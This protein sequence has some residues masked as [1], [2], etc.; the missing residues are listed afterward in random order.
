MLQGWVHR[1]CHKSVRLLDSV[2]LLHRAEI[3]PASTYT[4]NTALAFAP[5]VS[6]CLLPSWTIPYIHQFPPICLVRKVHLVS[7][8]SGRPMQRRP[9]AALRLKVGTTT[10]EQLQR[11]Q[12]PVPG[13]AV[14][15]GDPLSICRAHVGPQGRQPRRGLMA[16]GDESQGKWRQAMVVLVNR[17]I[18][19]CNHA[20]ADRFAK[21][22]WLQ[23]LTH[24]VSGHRQAV[25]RHNN[26]HVHCSEKVMQLDKTHGKRVSTTKAALK[27]LVPVSE[28]MCSS[29]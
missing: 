20:C 18:D 24:R 19:H 29:Y 13:G 27:R 5:C 9:R 28:N 25:R 26:A 15:R 1:P 12:V 14:G 10:R 16:P 23:S 11:A 22:A 8:L 4:Q 7:H 3:L 17:E 2:F 6:S 21:G